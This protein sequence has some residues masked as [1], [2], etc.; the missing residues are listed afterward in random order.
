M[1]LGRSKGPL[2]ALTL[3]PLSRLTLLPHKV[4]IES[5][6]SVNQ[7]AQTIEAVGCT[8]QLVG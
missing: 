6:K 2:T 3:S 1:A 8:G 5:R 4:D 7:F